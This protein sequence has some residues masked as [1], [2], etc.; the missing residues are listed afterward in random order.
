MAGKPH[1]DEGFLVL[2]TIHSAKGQE[3][4]TVYVQHFSAGNDKKLEEER[5]LAYAALTRAKNKLVLVNPFNLK[6]AVEVRIQ[7]QGTEQKGFST[8]P[9]STKTVNSLIVSST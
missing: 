1:I 3:W 5:R 8:A 9:Q 6:K 7:T 4:D 2:S